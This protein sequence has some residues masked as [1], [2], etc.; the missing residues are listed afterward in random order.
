MTDEDDLPEYIDRCRK[1]EKKEPRPEFRIGDLVVTDNGKTYKRRQ[2]NY[3]L[4]KIV[5]I[6]EDTYSKPP[7]FNYY[8]I[9]MKTTNPDMLHRIGR[10]FK[11]ETFWSKDA[12]LYLESEFKIPWL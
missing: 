1:R 9:V 5:D 4:I 3:N 7:V 12:K 10:L 11:I 6:E 8:G 2:R